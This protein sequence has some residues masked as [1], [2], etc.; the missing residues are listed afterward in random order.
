MIEI[1]ERIILHA[2]FPTPKEIGE[3]LGMMVKSFRARDEVDIRFIGSCGT[4]D[5]LDIGTDIIIRRYEK[6]KTKTS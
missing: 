3:A 4:R 1:K 5:C 2:R 6:T